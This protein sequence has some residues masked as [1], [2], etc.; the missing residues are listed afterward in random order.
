MT[1]LLGC[2]EGLLKTFEMSFERNSSSAKLGENSLSLAFS[3]GTSVISCSRIAFSPFVS[4]RL[5][6]WA[7][8]ISLFAGST[9]Y[10]TC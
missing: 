3:S 5:T 10:T 8:G 9:D 7:L 6:C 2:F 4:L 1:I